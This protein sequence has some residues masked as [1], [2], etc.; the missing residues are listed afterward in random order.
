MNAIAQKTVEYMEENVILCKCIVRISMIYTFKK[1]VYL[2]KKGL[3][4][5]HKR[6]T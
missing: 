2:S 3:H 1:Y 4:P 6:N 5:L